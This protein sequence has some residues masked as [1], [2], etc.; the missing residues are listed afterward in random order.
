MCAG[1]AAD[2]EHEHDRREDPVVERIA[3]EEAKT[4]AATLEAEYEEEV[5]TVLNVLSHLSAADDDH[6]DNQTSASVLR[7][8]PSH[9]ASASTA[10]TTPSLAQT[11]SASSTSIATSASASST[12][13][14][15]SRH[16]AK[17][18]GEYKF[19]NTQPVLRF[20]TPLNE[21]H[22]R[23]IRKSDLYRWYR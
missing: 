5:E 16:G 20:G 11:T 4:D 9:A 13:L 22:S 1:T 7:E 17:P 15:V 6:V 8:S 2:D 23:L 18:Q 10:A 21:H 19:W 3:S 12:H 14:P